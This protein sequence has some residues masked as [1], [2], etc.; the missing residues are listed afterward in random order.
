MGRWSLGHGYACENGNY[1]MVTMAI[2]MF[3][4]GYR[5]EELSELGEMAVWES[6]Q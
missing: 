2:C 5:V 6:C 4:G 3:I 1:C